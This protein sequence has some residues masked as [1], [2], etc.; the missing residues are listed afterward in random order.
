[1]YLRNIYK[2]KTQ[3]KWFNT[4]QVVNNNELGSIDNQTYVIVIQC[5]S[6][7]YL[8]QQLLSSLR[9]AF[10]I[11]T[12]LI[13]FSHDHYSYKM[14]QLIKT[15]NFAK[16]MQIFYPYSMQLH[17]NA[18]PGAEPKSCIEG[19][20]CVK[21]DYR[22]P[23]AA[24][25]KHH[26][27]W[28]ANQIFDHLRVLK[29]YT[30][31]ILFLEENNYVTEDVLV[32]YRLLI[33]TRDIHCPFCE[34]I[35][36]AAHDPDLPRYRRRRTVVAMEVWKNSMPRTAIAFD[37]KI[38]HNIKIWKEMFCYYNDSNWDQSLK[39]VGAEKWDGNIYLTAIDGPRVF[40]VEECDPKDAG[41]KLQNKVEDVKK[42]IKV[43]KKQL[44]PLSIKIKVT[45]EEDFNYTASGYWTDVRDH[46]LCMQF[47]NGS[48]WY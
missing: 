2:I 43:I 22:D 33:Y 7:I 37:R 39:H 20:P 24:Q 10:F 17:P 35:S 25:S 11:N 18:F 19:F 4:R 1:M 36:L 42:F 30:Q 38:W 28:Q 47:A 14:N 40:R 6:N 27:W 5:H 8:L 12:A 48:V 44:Y 41:C 45:A 31:P 13:I 34:M 32:V 29:N 26:W 16:Y 21:A 46:E 3:I 15:V 9:R 23:E